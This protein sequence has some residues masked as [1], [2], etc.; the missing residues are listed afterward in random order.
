MVLLFVLGR[1]A[2]RI[3]CSPKITAGKLTKKKGD[4]G[5]GGKK[6]KKDKGYFLSSFFHFIILFKQMSTVSSN[7]NKPGRPPSSLSTNLTAVQSS[8]SDML[9]VSSRQRQSKK[10]EV[11]YIVEQSIHLIYR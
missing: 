3:S 8:E 6:R 9:S 10:D 4:G 5:S 1:M 2:H 11:N 7:K